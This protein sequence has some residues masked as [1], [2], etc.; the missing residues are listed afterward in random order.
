MSAVLAE[1]TVVLLQQ[2]SHCGFIRDTLKRQ[3]THFRP[4]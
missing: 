4:H 3:W 1:V 2:L